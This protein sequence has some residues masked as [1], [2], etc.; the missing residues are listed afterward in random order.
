MTVSRH[1]RGLRDRAKR[2]E[3]VIVG[4][5]RTRARWVVRIIGHPRLKA[6]QLDELLSLHLLDSPAKLRVRHRALEL[7]EQRV[8]GDELEGAVEPSAQDLGRGAAGCEQRRDDDVGVENR[9][10]RSVLA[11]SSRVLSFDGK[12]NRLAFAKIVP[13]PQPIEQVETQVSAKGLLDDVS[14]APVSYTH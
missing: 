14:I 1:D 5:G 8:G 11:T 9:P 7:G 3:R 10:H 6:K 2:D 13:S 12:L 4:V